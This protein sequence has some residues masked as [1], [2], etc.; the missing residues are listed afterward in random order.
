MY[1][2]SPY[3]AVNHGYY[4]FRPYHYSHIAQQ[5]MIAARWGADPR[6]P[7]RSDLFYALYS[8]LG[9]WPPADDEP[10]DDVP[11]HQRKPSDFFRPLR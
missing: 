11:S 3:C 1:P 10:D 2:E 5:Q 7:Y 6:S 9:F 4:Y 8:E